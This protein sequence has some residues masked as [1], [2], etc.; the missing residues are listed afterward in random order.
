MLRKKD[1][2]RAFKAPVPA[3]DG[4]SGPNRAALRLDGRLDSAALSPQVHRVI[5]TMARLRNVVSSLRQEGVAIDFQAARDV[6]DGHRA[7]RPGEAEV[8]R[9]AKAY[10]VVHET[11]AAKLPQLTKSYIRRLHGDLYKGYDEDH[12]RPGRFKVEQNGVGPLPGHWTFECTPPERTEAE[13]DALFEW[14]DQKRNE[15]PSAGVAS[16]FFAEFQ[17]IH[18]FHDGNGRIGRVVNA[19]V[20]KALGFENIGLVPLDARFYR[21]GETY[22]EELASTNDGATWNA[23]AH[24]YARELRKAYEAAVKMSD[25]QPVLDRQPTDS[26]RHVLTWSLAGGGGWFQR[27]DIPLGGYKASTLS[28]ALRDLREQD[29]LEMQGD[30]KGAK[31]RLKT[32]LLEEI[33]RG[34]H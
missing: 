28:A 10:A 8:L 26:A 25:L 32:G 29:V 9:F 15:D 23:W 11:P 33:F 21:S 4:V 22:Y 1:T 6:L 24:F 18:P 3:G 13:L 12:Y 5:L 17:A 7:T 31:Y 2:S 14:F 27:G 19:H 34:I 16:T 20:L 30:R